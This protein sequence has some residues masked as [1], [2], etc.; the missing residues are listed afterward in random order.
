MEEK[1]GLSNKPA[2]INIQVHEIQPTSEGMSF[3]DLL[4]KF[5]LNSE[6]KKAEDAT[7]SGVSGIVAK[8]FVKK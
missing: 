7:Q 8:P 4:E 1:Q 5:Y 6:L 2:P 3:G